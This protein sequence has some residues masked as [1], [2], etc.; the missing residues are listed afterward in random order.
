MAI[1]LGS[2]ISS[3]QAQRRLSDATGTLSKIF[4]QLSSGLRINRASDDAAGLAIAQDLNST[5]RVYSKAILNAND[6]QSILSIAD[7]TLDNLSSVVMRIRELSE[8]SA[9]GTYQSTTIFTRRRGSSTRKR[10]LPSKPI[11]II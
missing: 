11:C 2:N 7:S 6:G 1:S 8:Q 3:L 4:E 9:N 5:T 10:I